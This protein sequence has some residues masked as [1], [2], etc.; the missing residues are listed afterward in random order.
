MKMWGRRTPLNPRDED[1]GYT[2]ST[3]TQMKKK[4]FLTVQM[5]L[6]DV[7]VIV[8]MISITV[9]AIV[10]VILKVLLFDNVSI[11]AS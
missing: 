2:N 7:G 9:L 10:V 11:L 3:K 4:Y 5:F 8:A 1:V 6:D